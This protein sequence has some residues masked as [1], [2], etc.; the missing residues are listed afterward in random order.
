MPNP[1]VHFE[2]TGRDGPA[3]QRFY[4][5]VFEWKIDASNPMGYGIVDNGGE[6]V[7]GGI[8][9]TEQGDGHVTFYVAVPDLEETLRAVGRL[10]AE[11]STLGSVEKLTEVVASLVPTLRAVNPFQVQCNYLG[12][13]TRNASSSISEGDAL[14]TWFRFIPIYQPDEIRQRAEPAPELHV[15]PYPRVDGECEA[16]NEPFVRGQRIGNP[17]GRQAP[18]TEDTGR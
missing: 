4:G 13:W 3:L 16:G 10:V 2:V 11:P 1:V 7:N 8:G 9:A 12:V 15:N 5:D 18:R 14:G 6:G 17:E